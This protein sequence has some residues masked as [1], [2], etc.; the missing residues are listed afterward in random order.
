MTLPT[1]VAYYTFEE[2]DKDA[3]KP[4]PEHWHLTKVERDEIKLSYVEN[5]KIQLTAIIREDLSLSVNVFQREA[6]SC[7]IEKVKLKVFLLSLNAKKICPAITDP[8]L[9]EFAD[10]NSDAGYYKQIQSL[11]SCSHEV[12]SV[13]LEF[14]C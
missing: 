6:L 13:A 9:Q 7:S 10:I 1:L 11:L 4:L 3:W 12:T 8:D 5:D 2:V 14:L